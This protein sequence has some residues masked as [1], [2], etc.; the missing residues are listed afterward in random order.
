MQS[1]RAGERRSR[2][3]ALAIQ[4]RRSQINRVSRFMRHHGLRE[5]RRSWRARR[6]LAVVVVQWP[7]LRAT[8]GNL[9]SQLFPLII[10]SSVRRRP[11]LA[12]VFGRPSERAQEGKREKKILIISAHN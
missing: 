12:G 8:A 2:A 6:P 10:Q 3:A 9:A 1:R 5:Q 4:T 11:S 7:G